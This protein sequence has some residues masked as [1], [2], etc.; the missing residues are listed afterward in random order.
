MRQKDWDQFAGHVLACSWR[1][2]SSHGGSLI[3]PGWLQ[4]SRVREGPLRNAGRL[5]V[6]DAKLIGVWSASRAQSS[7]FS[8][9]GG[10][11]GKDYSSASAQSASPWYCSHT[12][13]HLAT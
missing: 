9:K 8:G 4:A 13:L 5:L 1:S 11:K 6:N 10:D 12:G 7:S 2:F 3:I